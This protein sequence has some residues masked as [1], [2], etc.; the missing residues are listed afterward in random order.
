MNFFKMLWK[1]NTTLKRTNK[2]NKNTQMSKIKYTVCKDIS[3]KECVH[4]VHKHYC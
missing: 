1:Q 4:V 2:D 3:M